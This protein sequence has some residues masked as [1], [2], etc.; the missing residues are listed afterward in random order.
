MRKRLCLYYLKPKPT[1]RWFKG[2][3]KIRKFIRYLLRGKDRISSLEMVFINLCKGLK[4]LG[5]DFT[6]NL[7]F[8]QLRANDIP[9]VL[10]QGKNV[11]EGYKQNNSI[12]AGIGLM[13]HPNEWPTLFQDYPVKTYLQ[14]SAWT[15]SIYNKWY[16]TGS[17]VQWQAGIN[18]EYWKPINQPKKH[19]LIY[20]KFLW[21][22]TDNQASL[23]APIIAQLKKKNISYSI[24]RYGFYKKNDFKRLLAGSVAMLFLCEHESQGLAYQQAMAMNVPILAWEQGL[25]LDPLRF[26]WGEHDPIA[27]SSVPYFDERCGMKFNDFDS[28]EQ[29]FP[30]FFQQ[31]KDGRFS[32]RAYVL[33]NLTIEKSAKRMLEIVNQDIG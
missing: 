26:E 31:A 5:I 9:I 32:P 8:E 10:G 12:I 30:T 22:K 14:H 11:L 23:T 24:I 13:T 29:I 6:I 2:D 3:E 28:F 21:N 17:T 4:S 19:I 20:E 7:P 18:S 33:E 27:A 25:W 15:T 1:F 16:G